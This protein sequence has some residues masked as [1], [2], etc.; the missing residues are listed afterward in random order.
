MIRS[1]QASFS[2]V[3]L[4]EAVPFEGDWTGQLRVVFNHTVKFVSVCQ[5]SKL[6]AQSPDRI[7]A[8]RSGWN[9]LLQREKLLSCRRAPPHAQPERAG[10]ERACAQPTTSVDPSSELLAGRIKMQVWKRQKQAPEGKREVKNPVDK[11]HSL[12][13][14]MYLKNFHFLTRHLQQ[15]PFSWSHLST[16]ILTCG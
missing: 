12:N 6:K 9:R 8:P 16:W 3:M 1:P 13:L 7:E 10:E 11:G 5:S 4:Q 14:E 2:P 15:H